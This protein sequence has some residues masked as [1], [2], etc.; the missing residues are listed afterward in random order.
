MLAILSQP[1]CVNSSI[2]DLCYLSNVILYMMSLSVRTDWSLIM[3]YGV[4]ELVNIDQGMACYLMAPSYNLYRCWLITHLEIQSHFWGPIE[5]KF[6][7][8]IVMFFWPATSEEQGIV[9]AYSNTFIFQI[10][11]MFKP[12]DLAFYLINHSEIWQV[13]QHYCC[14]VS[15]Q[16]SRWYQHL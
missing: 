5:L 14:S 7:D 1:Q 15:S 4:E 10:S 16:S 9:S 12:Q 2:W 11:W 8:I 3:T 13:S 6:G